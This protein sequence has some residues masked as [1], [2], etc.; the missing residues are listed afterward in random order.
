MVLRGGQV[1]HPEPGRRAQVWLGVAL[2]LLL[3]WGWLAH[4]PSIAVEALPVDDPAQD[5][6]VTPGPVA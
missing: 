2:L 5:L 1:V 3:L 6:L 4:H